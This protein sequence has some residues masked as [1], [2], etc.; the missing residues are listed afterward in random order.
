M[1]QSNVSQSITESR[2][3]AAGGNGSCS[4]QCKFG[5]RTAPLPL[6][7]FPYHWSTAAGMVPPSALELLRL[8][9]IAL[10]GVV[11]LL[12]LVLL[13]Q[14]G[15]ASLIAQRATRRERTLKPQVFQALEAYPRSS[16]TLPELNRFDRSVVRD[17]LL[18]LAL[19]LRG[20]SGEAIAWLYG[21]LG[22]L[23]YDLAALRSWRPS[24]RAR[25]AADLGLIRAPRSLAPLLATLNDPDLH[26]R[27][28]AVWAVGQLGD[29]KALALLVELL[30]DA[31][32]VVGRRAQEVLA[33]R[34]R[35]VEDAILAYAHKTHTPVGRMAAV[36]LIGWLRIATAATLLERL[37]QDP[38]SEMRVKS[39]KAASAIGDPR[40]LDSFHLRLTDPQWEVRCQAARG[41]SVLGSPTSI[42]RLEAALRDDHWWVRFYAAVALAEIGTPGESALVEALSDPAPLVRDMA[43]YLLER[44][45]AVP[46]LP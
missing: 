15:L 29:R 18:G 14:H 36:E 11:L 23:K 39:V 26:V 43:R 12:F 33:E 5:A 8:W 3:T 37:M 9:V 40:F 6:L 35:E 28:S 4:G 19:D 24:R 21:R 20:D 41:L 31:S 10:S 32:T 7:V 27:Q 2:P 1:E 17:M 46:A 44:R 13:A 30:G 16:V 45:A 25:A 22:L 34:G 42:P 38:D